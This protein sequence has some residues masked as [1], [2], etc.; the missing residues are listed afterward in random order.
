M[1]LLI[2]VVLYTH[3]KS[4]IPECIEVVYYIYILGALF[5]AFEVSHKDIGSTRQYSWV[6]FVIYPLGQGD[7][8]FVTALQLKNALVPSIIRAS[9]AASRIRV[10]AKIFFT[11]LLTALDYEIYNLHLT[12]EWVKAITAVQNSGS[13]KLQ[14]QY[15]QLM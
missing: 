4:V 10:K 6:L 12:V 9:T 8:F 5:E 15:G 11:F 3:N 1:Y 2:T 13:T 14:N 7:P